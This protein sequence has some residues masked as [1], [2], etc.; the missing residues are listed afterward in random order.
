MC[1]H[2][3]LKK[4]CS[5]ACLDRAKGRLS[6]I[7]VLLFERVYKMCVLC[8]NKKCILYIIEFPLIIYILIV[9]LMFLS[10]LTLPPPL[11]PSLH[12][13]FL[14]FFFFTN[15]FLCL[16]SFLFFFFLFLLNQCP[17]PFFLL[18]PP[19]SLFFLQL[20][21]EWLGLSLAHQGHGSNAKVFTL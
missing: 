14:F 16:L 18:P 20:G 17:P 5:I 8:T 15:V 3:S 6:F 4:Q 10:S 7:N 13:V 9:F 12:Q 2:T 21:E 11:P 1:C 19:L